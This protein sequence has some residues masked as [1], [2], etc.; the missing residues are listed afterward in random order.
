LNGGNLVNCEILGAGTMDSMVVLDGIFR[1]LNQESGVIH[2]HGQLIIS[3]ATAY[4]VEAIGIP[5]LDMAMADSLENYG[6]IHSHGLPQNPIF[7]FFF[8]KS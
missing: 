2:S 6:I 4:N 7:E 3:S 5:V 1:L 8:H